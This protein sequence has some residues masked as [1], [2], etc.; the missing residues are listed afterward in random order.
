MKHLADQYRLE[1]MNPPAN[2]KP[3]KFFQVGGSVRDKILGVQSKDID[4][5]VETESFDTMRDAILAR[6]GKIFLETPQ[7]FTIRAHVPNLG[8]TDYVLCRKDG[9]Y[10]DGRHPETVTAGTIMDD[11]ARRDFTMNA[12]AIDTDTGEILD[13]HNGRADIEKHMIRCVGEPLKR[14]TEDRLRV[15]RALRFAITKNFVIDTKIMSMVQFMSVA[16]FDGV[17]TE[18]IR[19]ELMKAFK[20]DSWRTMDYLVDFMPVLGQVTRA[21]NIWFKPTTE[22]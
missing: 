14:F 19:E 5:A 3:A 6:G 18:R 16:Q 2:P 4:Y 10:K 9:E 13:P 17:S 20:A 1:F 11:L 15:F 7:Y 8:A 21:R 22:K 12:I